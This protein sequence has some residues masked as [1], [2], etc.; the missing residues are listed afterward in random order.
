MKACWWHP[1]VR[2]PGLLLPWVQARWTHAWIEGRPAVL[3]VHRQPLMGRFWHWTVPG[4]VRSLPGT[5][6]RQCNARL[7]SH[8]P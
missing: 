1:W 5:S 6:C 2:Q 7:V 8:M 4:L 3:H